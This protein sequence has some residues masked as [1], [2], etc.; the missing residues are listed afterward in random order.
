MTPTGRL[1]SAPA[2]SEISESERLRS[3]WL[4]WMEAELGDCSIDA[5]HFICPGFFNSEHGSLALARSPIDNM[6]EAWS[7]FVGGRELCT[8]LDDLGAGAVAFGAP[9]EDIWAL[10]LRLLADELAWTRPGPVILYEAQG[11][12]D[13]VAQAYRFLFSENYAPPPGRGEL[14]LYC[15]PRRLE[16]YADVPFFESPTLSTEDPGH[17][18]LKATRQHGGR[19]GSPTPPNAGV[20]QPLASSP[21]SRAGRAPIG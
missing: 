20:S 12:I 11:P 16:R 8:F 5:V 9:Y 13:A 15:H 14:M 10:G 21:R 7:H 18:W 4:R 6:D 19:K 1:N 3:P 2:S 17:E